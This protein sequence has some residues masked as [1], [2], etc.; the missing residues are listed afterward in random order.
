MEMIFFVSPYLFGELANKKFG[1][2]YGELLEMLSKLAS[3]DYL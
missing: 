1:K 2:K 3:L